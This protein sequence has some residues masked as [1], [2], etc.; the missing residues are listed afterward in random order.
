ML[1]LFDLTFLPNF[2]FFFFCKVIGHFFKEANPV[3]DFI[4]G[5]L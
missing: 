4:L 3:V 1:N 5:L 2:F